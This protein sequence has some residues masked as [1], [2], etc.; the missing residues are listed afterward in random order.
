MSTGFRID[1]TGESESGTL[2]R[3][4]LIKRTPSV[5]VLDDSVTEQVRTILQDKLIH[6]IFLSS[7]TVLLLQEVM[8]QLPAHEQAKLAKAQEGLQHEKRE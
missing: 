1:E 2:P 6:Y 3:R 5:A 7:L 4:R 8:A